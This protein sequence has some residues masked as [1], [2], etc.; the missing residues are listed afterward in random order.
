[1]LM[2]NG[3]IIPRLVYRLKAA[4]NLNPVEC[5][6]V[7]GQ[8]GI[9]HDHRKPNIGL[10]K[11]NN[12]IESR[13][14]TECGAKPEA[15][16]D[17]GDKSVR[18]IVHMNVQLAPP[19]PPP[20]TTLFA[21]QLDHIMKQRVPHQDVAIELEHIQ[22]MAAVCVVRVVYWMPKSDGKTPSAHLNETQR[23]AIAGVAAP[24]LLILSSSRGKI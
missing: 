10:T 2:R 6:N 21:R 17:D 13:P 18:A 3:T 1:M 22:E 23:I 5:L 15:M 14:R 11:L 8:A 16:L 4:C 7:T 20:P 24:V 19:P 9:L 12:K